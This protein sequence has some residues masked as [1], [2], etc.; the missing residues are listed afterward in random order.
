MVALKHT[1]FIGTVNSEVISDDPQPR[2]VKIGD[3]WDV[4]VMNYSDFPIFTRRYP[5]AGVENFA[6]DILL[7]KPCIVV[8]HHNDCHD[9]Y[10]CLTECMERL[11]RLNVKL[12]WTSLAEVVRRSFRQR[13]VSP[14]VV[15]VEVYA[16]EARVVNTSGTKK[17]FRFRKRESAADAVTG[18]TVEG[19]PVKWAFAQN[20][21]GF[22][23]E[24]NPGEAKTVKLAF[25]EI[26]VA[27]MAG[28]GAVYE[29][30]VRLR[31]YLCEVRD[32]YFPQKMFSK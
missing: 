17:L 5:W 10:Q 4:A 1:E 8:I 26:P 22:E 20:Q 25:K 32:N 23:I 21:V 27:G 7:G 28:E 13:E 15:E 3:Y 31:R 12:R 14:G 30:K 2:P 18:V 24:L 16:S 6:F 9:G 19:Q 29:A 11:N